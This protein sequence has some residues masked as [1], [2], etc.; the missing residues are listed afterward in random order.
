MKEINFQ[1]LIKNIE[2]EICKEY[3]RYDTND[4]NDII[5]EL[6]KNDIFTSKDSIQNL[7]DMLEDLK[8]EF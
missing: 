3:G 2:N 5:V 8:G 6:I 4:L 1:N 7:I